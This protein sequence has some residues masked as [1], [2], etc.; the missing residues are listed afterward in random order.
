[1]RQNT[2]NALDEIDIVRAVVMGANAPGSA[3]LASITAR[4]RL[5]LVRALFDKSAHPADKAALIRHVLRY[6][7]ERQNGPPQTLQT[8]IGDEWPTTEL[9]Q[10]HGIIARPHPSNGFVLHAEPWQPEWLEMPDCVSPE[11][12]AFREDTRRHLPA[13]EGDPF[14]SL[15]ARSDYLCEGQQA[16][17]RSVLAAPPGSTL[18]VNLPTGNG[19]SLCAHLPCVLPTVFKQSAGLTV[20]VVPTVALCI[21]QAAIIQ[22][23]TGQ[24]SAYHGGSSDAISVR[25]RAVISRILDGTQ[26]AVFTSP[27]ALMGSLRA[28][29][30][31]AARNGY[32]RAIV[33]DEAH[34]IGQWGDAFRPAFQELSG[35]R[36]ALLRVSPEPTFRT[37][38]MSATLTR[39]CLSTLET[40]FGHPGPVEIVSAV[41]LRP[42]PDYWVSRCGNQEIQRQRVLEAIRHLPRPLVLYATERALAKDWWNLLRQSGYTRVGL[43]TGETPNSEREELIRK[44]SAGDLD[45]VTATSA[46]GLGIDQQDVRAV[47]HACVPETLD[48]LY[49]EVGRGGRDGNASVSLVIYTNRDL[50]VAQRMTQQHLITIDLG[51]QRWTRMFQAKSHSDTDHGTWRIPINIAPGFDS[52]YIDMVSDLSTEWNLSTLT[53]MCRAGLIAL[54]DTPPSPNLENSID[55]TTVLARTVRILDHSHL[56]IARWVERVEPLREASAEAQYRLFSLLQELL[57]RKRCVADILAD[58]YRIPP[59]QNTEGARGVQVALS[60]GGCDFCRQNSIAPFA[61]PAPRPR[62][63]WRPQPAIGDRLS[64]LMRGSNLLA[65]F[66]SATSREAERIREWRKV[67]IWAV[68]QGIRLVVAPALVLK[69][70]VRQSPSLKNVP[71]FFNPRYEQRRMP[72]VPTLVIYT[73]GEGAL[74]M[75][76]WTRM[77]RE[78]ENLTCPHI[79]L[80]PD[81]LRDPT[82]PD[83]LLLDILSCPAVSLTELRARENL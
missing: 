74:D 62:Y 3:A 4:C 67:A 46:F 34:I 54:D 65:I 36:K 70:F 47:V 75:A 78:P 59:L 61:H 19:K 12:A 21:D 68:A 55:N 73:S 66:Y 58:A 22:R 40:L 14:L 26:R 35:L 33:V 57:A 9:W 24:E 80:L 5:R 79:L 41:Q 77:S 29:V 10:D 45:I 60:C 82:R 49:Q 50:E 42:E 48:R 53:L 17:V 43:M 30:Y 32:L 6:E 31:H 64:N 51:H 81:D 2:I 1:M 20:I 27:E 28:P 39:T 25:N 83:R 11:A 52:R 18:I 13:V 37:V 63:P 56:D 16:A 72:S 23:H 15:V 8:P 76:F 44:W 7:S 69:E 38:L 71:L